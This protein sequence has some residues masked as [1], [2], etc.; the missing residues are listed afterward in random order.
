[1]R[2]VPLKPAG[3]LW[4]VSLYE[5]NRWERDH[6]GMYDRI[7]NMKSELD[8]TPPWHD[9]RLMDNLKMA[10]KWYVANNGAEIAR[11]NKL[12]VDKLYNISKTSY[13]KQRALRRGEPVPPPG[14]PMSTVVQEPKT[15]GKVHD[16]LRRRNR[17]TIEADNEAL[18]GRILSVKKTIDLK[19]FRDDFKQH[20]AYSQLRSRMPKD[21]LG[22]SK[23]P[24]AP[25]KERPPMRSASEGTRGF[26]LGM[27][28]LRPK[29]LAA[30]APQ[31]PPAVPASGEKR[32]PRTESGGGSGIGFAPSPMV[33][34]RS[35]PARDDEQIA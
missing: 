18:V 13:L 1:M 25:K 15:G 26:L 28:D 5:R 32:S 2:H 27:E 12:L 6:K 30:S 3:P 14:V 21:L 16:A 4:D 8:L 20:V 10:K 9:E 7:K 24:A 35:L 23:S 34:V 29:G 11:E 33:F 31:L 17:G 22:P 19:G